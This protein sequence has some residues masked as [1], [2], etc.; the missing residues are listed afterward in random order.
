M[1][2]QQRELERRILPWVWRCYFSHGLICLAFFAW[3]F[4]FLLF[5]CKEREKWALLTKSRG[6]WGW[7]ALL[8]LADEWCDVVLLPICR[9]FLE[10][11]ALFSGESSLSVYIYFRKRKW[12]CKRWNG[13]FKS[14]LLKRTRG[15][16]GKA[17]ASEGM[18]Q[19]MIVSF[20]K[21]L[22][23]LAQNL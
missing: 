15:P 7:L 2:H 14:R 11:W 12:K 9:A 1:A 3:L 8:L 18:E 22:F 17:G 16:H 19:K 6:R 20:Q 4:F 21:L 23:F 10:T 13:I 5:L